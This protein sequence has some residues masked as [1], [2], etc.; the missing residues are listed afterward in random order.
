MS[1]PTAAK[2]DTHAPEVH[3]DAQPFF[4]QGSDSGIGVVLIH[5]L[6]ASPTE[7]GPL[8]NAILSYDPTATVSCPLLPGHGTTPEHLRHTPPQAWTRTVAHEIDRVAD[9]CGQVNVI[10]M[11]LGGVLAAE[12]ALNDSRVRTAALLAPV[13]GLGRMRTALIAL[14]RPV[15]AYRRKGRRSLENHRAK[16]LF[17]YDRYPLNSVLHVATLGRH[18]RARLGEIKVPVLLAG[19]RFDRYVSWSTIES[20]AREIGDEQV[21]LVKCPSS[22]HVLPHEPDAE[23]LCDAILEFLARHNE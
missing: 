10:G 1:P 14:A 5:G 19:G 16:K 13:F 20:L 2:R 6:T 21:V 12:A 9:V 18:V 7:V 23:F 11:S 15:L 3:P 22:G 17:S 8:A 4:H